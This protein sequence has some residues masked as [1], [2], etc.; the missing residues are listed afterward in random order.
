MPA[1]EIG[2]QIGYKKPGGIAVRYPIIIICG[3]EH[4]V[5][6]YLELFKKKRKKKQNDGRNDGRKSNHQWLSM[7][8]TSP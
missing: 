6:I 3:V 1:E 8:S 5:N 4:G 7:V 2:Y